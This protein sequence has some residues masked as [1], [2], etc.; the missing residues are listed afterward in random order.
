MAH[1]VP[2]GFLPLGEAFEEACSKLENCDELTRRID[3]LDNRITNR[4]ANGTVTDDELQAANNELQA[5]IDEFDA[6]RLRVEDRVRMAALTK[7]LFPWSL[8]PISARWERILLDPEEWG[9]LAFG[10]SAVD[11]Y[12]D[13]IFSP[14]PDTE[15]QPLFV[16]KSEFQEWLAAQWPSADRAASSAAGNTSGE[17]RKRG[18][19]AQKFRRIKERMKADIQSGQWTRADLEN[20]Q[21]K[22]LESKYSASRDTVR[23][24]RNEL[25]SEI[26]DRQI[27]ANDK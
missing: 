9:R 4:I 16:E 8:N 15:G 23:A 3:E 17:P 5:R 20:A 24:A 2:E 21:E 13:P 25:L 11:T 22:E 7:Q 6:A 18:P 12:S 19:K 14:G 27:T 1:F 10:F 26:V